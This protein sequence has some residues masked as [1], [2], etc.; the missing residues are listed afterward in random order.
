MHVLGGARQLLAH[1]SRLED[2]LPF[3]LKQHHNASLLRERG[4]DASY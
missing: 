2:S 1:Q 3:L 4:T